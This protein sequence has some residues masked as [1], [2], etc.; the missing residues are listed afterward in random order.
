MERRTRDDDSGTSLDSLSTEVVFLIAEH[1]ISDAQALFE[2][3]V[4]YVHAV[5]SRKIPNLS[6]KYALNVTG[7]LSLAL[8]SRRY[9]PIAQEVLYRAPLTR[10]AFWNENAPVFLFTRTL[11]SSPHLARHINTLRLDMPDYLFD[12]IDP[13]VTTNALV[14]QAQT[15]IDSLNWMVL[16]C[17]DGWKY[18]LRKLRQ[19]PFLAL[20]LS[21]SPKLKRLCIANENERIIEDSLL[22]EMFW[23]TPVGVMT[24]EDHYQAMERLVSCP[25]LAGLQHLRTGSMAQMSM[26]PFFGL[27]SLTSLDLALN[28]W[29]EDVTVPA[30]ARIKKLR[31]NCRLTCLPRGL[32]EFY[33][34]YELISVL[35]ESFPRLQE[36]E[37]YAGP[38]YTEDTLEIAWHDQ[39]HAIIYKQYD[40]L[41]SHL[42]VV[43][44]TLKR[45]ELPRSWW[46]APRPVKENIPDATSQP[47][48]N[49]GTIADTSGFSELQ[50]LVTH[51]TAILKKGFEDT[52]VADP[53][54]T[55]PSSIKEITVYGAH[56]GLWSW[57]NSILDCEGSQFRCLRIIELKREEPV[58]PELRLS[59][60]EELKAT[61][62]KLCQKLRKSS[63]KIRG[64]L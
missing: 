32:S 34:L 25:G 50:T 6:D 55:L 39:K 12:Q 14:T 22:S 13:S 8:A 1:L 61:Q 18:Q 26:P 58:H 10:N 35:L 47:G 56:D 17:K 7:L 41:V 44:S 15:F 63:I 2:S 9:Q 4:G 30:L 53:V 43:S 54:T 49:T 45:L 62:G 5:S 20:I 48:A 31:L 36:L 60:L 46:T 38:P 33:V 64:D 24:E 37:L 16:N 29:P 3:E 23:S 40:E 11:L 21:L 57:V 52:E 59:T 42:H 27:G 28:N 19:L 51:S